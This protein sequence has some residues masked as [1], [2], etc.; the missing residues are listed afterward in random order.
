MSSNVPDLFYIDRRHKFYSRGEIDQFLKSYRHHFYEL[1]CRTHTMENA[2]I[3]EARKV[4]KKELYYYKVEIFC[5]QSAL[6]HNPG[7]PAKKGACKFRIILNLAES[8]DCLVINSDENFN[9]FH[10][11]A[12]N[13]TF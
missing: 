8:S 7:N 11:H 9:I 12:I 13:V 10:D 5:K 2:E 6:Y 1:K 4:N 3:L